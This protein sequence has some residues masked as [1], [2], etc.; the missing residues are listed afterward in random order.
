MLALSEDFNKDQLNYDE[1]QQKI[2]VRK[3]VYDRVGGGVV[4]KELL[5]PEELK[6]FVS[7]VTSDEEYYGHIDTKKYFFTFMEE[8]H[9]IIQSGR[10]ELP[11]GLS[12]STQFSP[13]GVPGSLARACNAHTGRWCSQCSCRLRTG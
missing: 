11:R 6:P 12:L 10:L 13:C 4:E 2:M 5:L 7:D 8:F 1:E 9:K 3:F